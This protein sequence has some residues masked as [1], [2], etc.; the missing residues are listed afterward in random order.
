[1]KCWL[2]YL[3][4]YLIFQ[5]MRM[6]QLKNSA[7]LRK[8]NS[9]WKVQVNQLGLLISRD[10]QPV[11][12][13]LNKQTKIFLPCNWEVQKI[14]KIQ[15][16]LNSGQTASGLSFSWSLSSALLPIIF[17]LRFHMVIKR[18]QYL[19]IHMVLAACLSGIS[20][21]SRLDY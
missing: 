2:F 14:I 15:A 21:P 7:P 18:L 12:T 5:Y 19:W 4:T 13:V 16:W 8:Q 10:I 20:F 17:I 11:Q 9:T 3:L 1:M 6:W